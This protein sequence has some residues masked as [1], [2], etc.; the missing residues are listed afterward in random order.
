MKSENKVVNRNFDL[1]LEENKWLKEIDLSVVQIIFES[2][3][4]QQ[5][6]LE[7]CHGKHFF[8]IIIDFNILE[9][10]ISKMEEEI[11]QLQNSKEIHSK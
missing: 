7:I 3:K 1:L 11:D 10:F 2:V 8:S 4:D 6:A 5:N 9:M